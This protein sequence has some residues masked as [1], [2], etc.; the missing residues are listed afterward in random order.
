MARLSKEAEKYYYLQK[1]APSILGIPGHGTVFMEGLSLAK[2]EVLY[3]S[4]RFGLV[5]RRKPLD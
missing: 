5:K 1:G 4:G 3:K 2:A